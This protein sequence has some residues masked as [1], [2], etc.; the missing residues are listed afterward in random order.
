MKNSNNQVKGIEW[1]TIHS[2]P[3]I[4]SYRILINTIF[5]IAIAFNRESDVA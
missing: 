4:A 1:M 5:T 2:D 3:Y